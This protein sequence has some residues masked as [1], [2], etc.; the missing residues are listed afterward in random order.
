MASLEL[1]LVAFIL[2]IIIVASFLMLF[3]A[4]AGLLIL[5]RTGFGEKDA[6]DATVNAAILI[7]LSWFAFVPLYYIGLWALRGQTV[8]KMAVKIKVIRSDG[9]P[10]GPGH[11]VVRFVGYVV[12]TLPVFLGFLVA[13]VNRRRQALHDLLADTVVI[14]LP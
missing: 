7:V 4:A 1:R 5:L 12:S 14:E 2:D 6:S 10:L 9:G 3:A 11:A 8:G 13:T